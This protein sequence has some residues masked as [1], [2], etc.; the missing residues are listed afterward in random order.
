MIILSQFKFNFG[1]KNLACN[2]S[3]SV[4][5]VPTIA[6]ENTASSI[7]T[8]SAKVSQSKRLYQK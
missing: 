6:K 3:P 4:E 5:S 8:P 7:M 2:S 1:D